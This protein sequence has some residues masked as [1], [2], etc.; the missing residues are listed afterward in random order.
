MS[1]P[2]APPM[3][4]TEPKPHRR[5]R[6]STLL[7]L[8][9]SGGR[10]DR[11]RIA[12]T[13][14]GAAIGTLALA[15]AAT[16][17]ATGAHDGP[18]TSDLLNQPGLHPGVAAALVLLCVPVLAFVGQ[19]ARIGAPAR[20]RRLASLRLQGA[21]PA[22]VVRVA[23]GETGVSATLGTAVGLGLFFVLRAVLNHPVLATYSVDRDVTY[24]NGSIG[25]ETVKVTG[26]ALRLPTDVL[27]SWPAL[28]VI[29]L[30]LPLAS[31]FF[32]TWALRR[33]AITPFGVVRA[34]QHRPARVVPGVMFVAGTAAMA[35]FA[36][37]QRLLHQEN[38]SPTVTGLTFFGLFLITGLGL[39]MST[40]A[41]SNAI[42]TLLAR[43][44]RRPA[45]LLAGRRLIAAPYQAG[46]ANAA[47]LFIVLLWAFTQGYRLQLL[48]TVDSENDFY[49]RTL[50]LVNVGFA[51]GALIAAAG[52]LI[53]TVEGVISRR[54]TLAAMSAVGIPRAV[55]HRAVLAE[56]ILPLVPAVLLAAG[57]GILGARGMLGTSVHQQDL[58]ADGSVTFHVVQLP[59]PWT[60]LGLLVAG[61]L[62]AI[63]LASL[64]ALPLL[65]RSID[66]AELRAS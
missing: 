32:T 26:P 42:G 37:G 13:A 49:E 7:W 64:T 4:T 65:A 63:L 5:M 20:D 16:V 38:N 1:A 33:V 30:L 60:S 9:A 52:L 6:L 25:I 19:C 46:R 14:G 34:E 59:I 8:A 27:P 11:T 3:T 24:D 29:A 58:L 17:I 12:L 50:A 18:Y 36:T 45:L 66:P 57:A 61:T 41:L 47:L 51:A 53:G 22:D 62:L 39:L 31:A 28:L 35:T 48:A 44:T 54:R 23:A 43:G 40:S 2:T 15:G 10:A 21:T 55:L 56:A